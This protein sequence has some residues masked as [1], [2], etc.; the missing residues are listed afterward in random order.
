MA[1]NDFKEGWGVVDDE[2]LKVRTVSDSRRA[3]VV[4]WLVTEA[5][6]M[7]YDSF[8]D[9]QINVMWEAKCG[10]AMVLPVRIYVK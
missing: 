9:E 4:N 8:S 7:I 10:D 6:C 5:G 2:G 3:A 1:H